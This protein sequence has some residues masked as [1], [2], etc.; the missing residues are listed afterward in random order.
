ML[1]AFDAHGAVLTELRVNWAAGTRQ[2]SLRHHTGLKVLTIHKLRALTLS[3]AFPWGFSESIHA[4]STGEDALT[5]EM[6]SGDTIR[7][8]GQ[9]LPT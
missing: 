9:Y 8:D 3:R 2:V 5:I 6:Q 4:L 1:H 7:I